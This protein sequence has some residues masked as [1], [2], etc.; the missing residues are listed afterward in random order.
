ME[1]SDTN[2]PYTICKGIHDNLWNVVI[3]I[4]GKLFQ[5][6]VV[7][8]RTFYEEKGCVF[9]NIYKVLTKKGNYY[10]ISKQLICQ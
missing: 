3:N 1:N 8:G 6:L 10:V 5:C 7:M 9:S 4:Q 2:L